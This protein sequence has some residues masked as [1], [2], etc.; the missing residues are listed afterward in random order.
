MVELKAPEQQL[1]WP[2]VNPFESFGSNWEQ[3]VSFE[4]IIVLFWLLL[5]RKAI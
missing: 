2:K 4:S 1:R 5:R 3:V